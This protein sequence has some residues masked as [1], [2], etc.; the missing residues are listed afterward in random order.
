MQLALLVGSLSGCMVLAK[1]SG[2]REREGEREIEK[3]RER[4][5]ERVI[6]ARQ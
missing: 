5:K 1:V 4:E 6:R 2:R 3:E